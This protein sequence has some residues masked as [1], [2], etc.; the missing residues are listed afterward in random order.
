M[1]IMAMESINS[2]ECSLNATYVALFM[3]FITDVPLL[4]ASTVS[5]VAFAPSSIII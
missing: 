5:V 3:A 2:T 1:A 4:N